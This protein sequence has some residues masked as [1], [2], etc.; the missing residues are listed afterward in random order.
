MAFRHNESPL[1]KNTLQNPSINNFDKGK[2]VIL[3]ILH[4]IT[5]HRGVITI[6][7]VGRLLHKP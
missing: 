7:N 3:F 6:I 5:S 4:F 2:P 1:K